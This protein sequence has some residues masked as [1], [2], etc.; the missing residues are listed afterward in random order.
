[1]PCI[2]HLQISCSIIDLSRQPKSGSIRITALAGRLSE[3]C[4]KEKSDFSQ[5]NSS[6]SFSQSLTT[7]LS[8]LCIN[9]Q[10]RFPILQ[11]NLSLKRCRDQSLIEEYKFFVTLTGQ[12]FNVSVGS[13]LFYQIAFCKDTNGLAVA[14]GLYHP[15]QITCPL[16]PIQQMMEQGI[17][18][19]KASLCDIFQAIEPQLEL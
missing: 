3:E 7:F 10:F 6:L 4:G 17:C 2:F 19:R 5:L 18:A 11:Q 12:L 15:I 8:R 1:M 16:A 9:T 13:T 14:K